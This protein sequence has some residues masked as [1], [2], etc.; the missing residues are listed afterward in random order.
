VTNEEILNQLPESML[1]LDEEGRVIFFNEGARKFSNLVPIRKG[2]S[3]VDIVS[4]DR[5]EIVRNIIKQVRSK[6]VS[7]VSEAEYIDQSGRSYFFE[8]TYSPVQTEES[9]KMQICVIVHDITHHKTFEKKSIELLNEFTSLIENANALIFSVDSREYITEW[10]KEC[11]RVTKY[12]KNEVLAQKAITVI[13]ETSH[14][15]FA[16]VFN[17][18]INGTAI[19]NQ[20][21]L[22][23][24]KAENPITILVNATPKISI[25]KNVVGVMFVGQ[26]ITELSQ[27]RS[28]LE[29]K[30]KDRTES[31][32]LALEKERELVDLKN[33]FVSVAS[34]ELKMPLSTIDSSVNFLKA[35][36]AL[37][38][39]DLQRVTNIEKQ[40]THMKSLL[41]DVLTVKKA[42]EKK[43]QADYKT[44]NIT[45]FLNNLI[46]EVAAG[47]KHSHSVERK[48]DSSSIL[49]ESD[50]KLLR[51]IFLN[52]LGNAMKFSPG[53]KSIRL[54]V[55]Q[56]EGKVIIA[57]IDNGIGIAAQ[58]MTKI[59]EPFNRGSNASDIR[60]T[61]LG[62]SIVKR[63]VEAIEG[64][65]T[66]ESELNK[67]TTVTVTIN[68][69]R[70]H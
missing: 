31:L 38:S 19:S 65:L 67:G 40:V 4:K 34:H 46:E 21:L 16:S 69:L 47:F 37:N 18:V 49:I 35:S 2:A 56:R 23:K 42:D 61:G 9:G 68:Q 33:R 43:L 45:D 50:E 41:E 6:K 63:A 48:F 57:V 3:I 20:E 15:D 22:I 59:F 25:S 53:E 1:L 14:P 51:N 55:E 30:V 39:E 24:T 60:G 8:I 27:Y 11:I 5:Q 29:E 44:L 70:Q 28:S 10:N 13:D 36:L 54:N 64:S 12:E 58:D 26:D 62:M 66:V 7:Q 52:L 17:S 32:K